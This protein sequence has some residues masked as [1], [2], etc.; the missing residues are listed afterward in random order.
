VTRRARARPAPVIPFHLLGCAA[1]SPGL[2]T[3][4][5]WAKWSLEPR[6]LE[7]EGRP[8]LAFVPPLLRRRCDQLSRMML[9]VAHACCPAELLPEVNTVF[10]S[11][12]GAFG[13]M[14]EMLDE[15]A[16]QRPLSPAAFSHSVH[17]TQAGLFSIWARNERGSS[18]V[19]AGA[20]TFGHGLLEALGMLRAEPDRPVLYVCG[21][22]AIP[23]PVRAICDHDQGAYALA[24]LLAA[25]GEQA[26]LGVALDGGAGEPR[27]AH[28]D[29][30]EFLRWLRVGGDELRLGPFRFRRRATT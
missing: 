3:D 11:R 24:L 10:A 1:W 27:L 22:E 8:E 14:V 9:F 26:P 25:Q 5:Q 17:N 21:D 20:A 18:S 29:A 16:E 23:E 13:T 4:E 6:P 15:L 30:L 19:A 28:P 7:R 12:H 2:E